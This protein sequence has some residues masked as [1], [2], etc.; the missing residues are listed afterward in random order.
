MTRKG[1]RMNTN[2]CEATIETRDGTVLSRDSGDAT[3][4]EVERITRGLLAAAINAVEP[5]VLRVA[6]RGP[7]GVFSASLDLD[8]PTIAAQP[9]QARLLKDVPAQMAAAFRRVTK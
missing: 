9:W 2:Q 8:P 5:V 4:A 3:A 7:L 6:F 1:D